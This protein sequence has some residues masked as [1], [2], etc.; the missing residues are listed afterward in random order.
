VRSPRFLLVL[1]AGRGVKAHPIWPDV[2]QDFEGKVGPNGTWVAWRLTGANHRELGRSA[3]VFPDPGSA[4]R[5]ARDLHASSASSQAH[6]QIVTIPRTTQWSWRLMIDGV[7]VATSSRMFARHRECAYNVA[8]FM[9]AATI[10]ELATAN[11]QIPLPRRRLAEPVL[12]PALDGGP[13]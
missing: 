13:E 4:W 3:R 6:A 9:A 7:A 11:A 2:Y 10:A 1:G 8:T 5:D 12:D